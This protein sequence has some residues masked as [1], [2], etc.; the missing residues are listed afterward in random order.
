ML[1]LP[2]RTDRAGDRRRRILS[3]EAA[4]LSVNVSDAVT[5]IEE[6]NDAESDDQ[7][8][9]NRKGSVVREGRAPLE[10]ILTTPR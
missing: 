1:R 10:C 4:D 9:R 2:Y 5:F 6:S 8:R 7:Q 3:N